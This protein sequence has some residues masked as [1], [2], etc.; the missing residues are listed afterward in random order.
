MFAPCDGCYRVFGHP[1]KTINAKNWKPD[2]CN[3][4]VDKSFDCGNAWCDFSIVG[5]CCV[6]FQFCDDCLNNNA[7]INKLFIEYANRGGVVSGVRLKKRHKSPVGFFK[8]GVPS[9]GFYQ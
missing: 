7:L 2:V 6:E 9:G 3:V 5:E 4:P 1:L 8:G